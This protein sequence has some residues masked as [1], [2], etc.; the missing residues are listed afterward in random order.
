M[1]SQADAVLERALARLSLVADLSEALA[2][3]LDARE[4][5]ERVCRLLAQRLGD[6]CAVDL[7][8]D[9]GATSGI[10]RIC[11]SETGAPDSRWPLPAQEASGPLAEA[12]HGG[13]TVLF[14]ADDIRNLPRANAWDAAFADDLARRDATSA[15]VA[16][17]DARRQVLG[18]ICLARS[19]R[20]RPLANAERAILRGLAHRVGLALENA[21]LYADAENIAERMQRSLLPELP[22]VPSLAMAVR[23]LPSS[24]AAQ[25]G[26]DWYDAFRL[27]NGPTALIIGDVVGHDL[28]A[29]VAM[30]QVRNMLRGIACDRQEPPDSILRRLDTAAD[31][32][33]PDTYA[34]CVYAV[35]HEDSASPGGGDWAL[36]YTSAGHPPPLLIEAD[37]RARFLEDGHGPML[38]IDPALP[39]SS[40][41]EPIASGAALLLYSDGLIERRGET[42]DHGLARL[43]RHAAGLSEDSPDVLCDHVLDALEPD[44]GDDVAL[45]AVRLR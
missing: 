33:N 28:H 44:A 27:P 1:N 25:V 2:A 37:G 5:V 26:G 45:L 12:L 42:L 9:G 31:T 36:D 39:R 18:V 40:A 29:A 32:L 22:H 19:G 20:S 3:T 10:E 38:G 11:A 14:D 21:R 17:I 23:Y 6:W 41:T 24:T 35:L 43:R 34:S 30:S 15:I 8:R 16:P 4:G 7:V 13:G